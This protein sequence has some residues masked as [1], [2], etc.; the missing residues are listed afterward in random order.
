MGK[1]GMPQAKEIGLRTLKSLVESARNIDPADMSPQAQQAR[2][3]SE[4]LT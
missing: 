3:I 4:C 2:N 1:S